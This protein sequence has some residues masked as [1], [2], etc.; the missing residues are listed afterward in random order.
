LAPGVVAANFVHFTAHAGKTV[1]EQLAEIGENGSL[2][3]G[4]A[5]GSEKAEELAESEVEVGEGLEFAGDGG[6]FG[7]DAL[8]VQDEALTAGM[9]EAE[10]RVGVPAGIAAAAIV[11]GIK[12]TAT[13]IGG[14]KG[15]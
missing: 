5:I 3:A 10:G 6:E 7:G 12:A 15:S 13:E 1:Q 4:E 8:G 9:I 11:G 2:A 14:G